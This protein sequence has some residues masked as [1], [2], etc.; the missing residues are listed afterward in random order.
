MA[1]FQSITPIKIAQAEMPTSAGLFYTV[2]DNSRIFL[3]DINIANTTNNT[4]GA[5]IYLVPNGDSAG[6]ANALIYQWRLFSY[7]LYRWQGVQIMNA[8]DEIYIEAS[9][10]GLT[11][12]ASGAQAV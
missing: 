5:T 7:D 2:P 8:G 9:D 11:V 3:K 1:N 4:I 10:T 12:V 6:T